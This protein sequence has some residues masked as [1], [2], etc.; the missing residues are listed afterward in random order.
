MRGVVGVMLH[1][2]PSTGR[3]KALNNVLK[4]SSKGMAALGLLHVCDFVKPQAERKA[5]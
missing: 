2:Q 4:T 5:G 1:N 3:N